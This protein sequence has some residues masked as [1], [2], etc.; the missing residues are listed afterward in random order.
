MAV[1]V[2]ILVEPINLGH[3]NLYK[4]K[5]YKNLWLNYYSDFINS[6]KP[7]KI[8]WSKDFVKIVILTNTTDQNRR[9]DCWLYI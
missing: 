2:H 3:I 4:I 8:Y 6:P 7:S 9:H 1:D 5:L